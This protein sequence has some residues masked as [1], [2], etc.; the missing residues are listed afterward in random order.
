MAYQDCI[1][2]TRE[3][4]A[5]FA[6]RAARSFAALWKNTATSIGIDTPSDIAETLVRLSQADLFHFK[7]ETVFNEIDQILVN[8]LN[9][10][11]TFADGKGYGDFAIAN[12]TSSDFLFSDRFKKARQLIEAWK[13]FKHARQHVIDRRHAARIASV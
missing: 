8:R 10:I 1:H 7:D 5:L 9:K 11:G 3:E 12:D 6:I 4:E 13:A 2:Q